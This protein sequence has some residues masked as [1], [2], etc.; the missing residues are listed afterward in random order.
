MRDEI[1]LPGADL[2]KSQYNRQSVVLLPRSLIV[3][4]D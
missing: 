4:V 1:I 2:A 3:E